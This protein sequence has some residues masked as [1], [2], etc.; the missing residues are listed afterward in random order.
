[1]TSAARYANPVLAFDVPDPDVIA[2]AG[3]G[4]AMVASSFDRQPGL[5][6]WRSDDLV[7][8]RTAGFAGGYQPLVQPSGGV[9]AP[10][11]REHDGRLFITWADPDRGVFVVEAPAVEGPWSRPRLIIAGPGPIDPCPFWD[12]DGRAWIVHGWARSRAG[13]ANR[14]DIVEVDAGLTRTLGSSRVLIDGDR[15]EG[16]TVLEGPKLYRRGT[17][18]YV[19][20]PAGGVETGW[21]YV[22][23]S[24]DLAGPW[25]E[26]VVLEQG[27]TGIN[28]PHQG[29]WVA[30][31][32][33]EEWFLHFQHTP[34]HGRV[35]HLQPLAWGDDGWP[36]VGA[37]VAG[38]PPEPV[39]DWPYPT[40]RPAVERSTDANTTATGG[41]HGRGAD[42]SELVID[43]VCSSTG[44]GLAEGGT[45][46][47]P[48][49]ARAA[50][51]EVVLLEGEGSASLI[52]ADHH[53]LRVTDR[54]ADPDNPADP[55]ADNPA[56]PDAD[57]HSGVH[58]T[59][60][61]VAPP[62]RL[63]V[64][65]DGPAARFT[66]DGQP[67]GEWFRPT[68]SQWTGVEFGVSAHGTRGA[69]FDLTQPATS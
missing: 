41:W 31:A 46:A 20:A 44:V 37:A 12:D 2:L 15:V 30:G 57:A 32:D 66:V 9:W 38:G 55:G 52:G 24:P 22:F 65:L 59:V 54:P 40:P 64:E 6:L 63:G 1:M 56:D 21:Q 25:E 51:I 58:E 62:V 3:G 43:P 61:H 18:Y 17:D 28:G 47:R 7:Q 33:G 29:A 68:P 60:V 45:L 27:A 48:L 50:R 53:R 67:V 8:W 39:N 42:P 34:L 13:F 5:P 26:R 19:F 14:L 49:D 10:S 69:R 4:Y 11:L 35:L 16:C 36:R 23:R